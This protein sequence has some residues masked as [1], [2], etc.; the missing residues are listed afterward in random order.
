[1]HLLRE[2]WRAS[3]TGK[4][5]RDWLASERGVLVH[6]GG[7]SRRL[8]AYA[9]EGK[10]LIPVPVFRWSRGQ[11]LDQNLLDLQLPLLER[12]LAACAGPGHWLVASGDVLLRGEQIPVEMPPADVTAVGLWGEAGQATRHGVFFTPRQSSGKLEFMLQKPDLD[13]IREAT[14]QHYFMLDVGVWVLG[15]KAIEVLL[16]QVC[17]SDEENCALRPY[18]LYSD[19]GPALGANPAVKMP[20][21][22]ELKAQ[23]LPLE[24]GEFYHFGSGP[25][26]IHSCLQLQNRVI[27][28]RRISS[29]DIKPHPSMFV[30]NSAV[31]KG[32]LREDN[33]G[34]WIE[35]AYVPEGWQLSQNHLITGVPEN[36]WELQLAPGLCIDVVPAN[37]EFVLRVYGINDAFRGRIGDPATQFCGQGFVE[38][39]QQRGLRLEDLGLDAECDVQEAAIFPVTRGTPPQ[40]LVEWMLNGASE[41]GRQLYLASKRVSAERLAAIAD[42]QAVAAQRRKLR[43]ACLPVLAANARRSVFHHVDLE[44]LAIDYAASGLELPPHRPDAELELF[45]YVHDA[46]FRSEVMRQRGQQD[47][48]TEQAAAFT[49]LRTAMIQTAMDAPVRPSR[50]CLEDQIIWAR[51]PVRLDLAGGWTDTPPYCFISGGRV[52]NLA[53]ELNGQP[54]IQVFIRPRVEG[55]IRLRSIDLGV[56]QEIV[57]YDDLRGF[58]DIGSGFA[59]PKAALALCGFLPEFNADHPEGDLAD[60]LK[61]FGGGLEISLLCAVPKGSG[62][63]TS[64]ILAATVLAA[65]AEFCELGWDTFTIAQ[66]VLVLEQMLTSGGG[67][68]DQFGGIC[69]GLKYLETSAGLEQAPRIRWLDDYL[70][71]DPG[72]QPRILLYYTGITRT[73]KS[74]LGEIVRG[75]FLNSGLRL[76]ILQKIGDNARRLQNVIQEGDFDELAQSVALSWELNKALDPGT[77][78]PAIQ[79]L[80]DSVQ[81]HIAGAKL[82]GAGGGGYLLVLARSAD[83]AREIRQIL[84]AAP[85]NPRARFVEISLSRQGL[86]VTRS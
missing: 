51:S 73:A 81:H 49:A 4:S 72:L 23:L 7:Q 40:A 78:T 25:D 18:D 45:R 80:L 14:R 28:Q 53:V 65:L 5:F 31:G 43:Q 58:A 15:P 77:N 20:A 22:N 17:P 30:Q 27:D 79:T 71:T 13:Q 42:L 82:L 26:L 3:G 34:V 55:G 64:S 61:Q 1:M 57:S 60:F 86:Q 32:V 33:T 63:G 70:F 75:M 38:W 74:V 46:M 66:R 35:N 48:A 44:R 36:N 11:R 16:D 2:G 47:A 37:E 50:N 69:R 21:V 39:L 19:F 59:I 52:V 83:S 41:A 9:A 76:D 8:P 12:V 67:W 10:A 85:P 68:Q 56:S 29:P 6:A 62:L 24:D 54:P 84:H